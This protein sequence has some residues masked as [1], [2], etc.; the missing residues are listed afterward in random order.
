MHQFNKVELVKFVEPENSFK[1]LELLVKQATNILDL[2][3]LDYRIIE[4]CAGDLSFAAAKCFDL[5][6][7]VSFFKQAK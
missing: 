2:L 6:S 1:E 5:E 7:P 3:E 4:L